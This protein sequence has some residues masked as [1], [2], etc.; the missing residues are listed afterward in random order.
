V[1]LSPELRYGPAKT[2]GD[3][4]VRRDHV[5]LRCHGGRRVA[6]IQPEVLA[7]RRLSPEHQLNANDIKGLYELSSLRL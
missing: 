7:P 4:M 3:A 5:W 6:V 2:L 1:Q